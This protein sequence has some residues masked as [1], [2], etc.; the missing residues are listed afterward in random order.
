MWGDN[1][2]NTASNELPMDNT[3]AYFKGTCGPIST[4][5]FL[6]AILA[7]MFASPGFA[8]M[9]CKKKKA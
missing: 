7:I 6:P 2:F 8:Y 9:L 5:E 1:Y 3:L 4:P